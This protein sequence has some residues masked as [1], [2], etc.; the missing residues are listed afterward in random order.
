MSAM[1]L[2]GSDAVLSLPLLSNAHVKKALIPS[3]VAKPVSFSRK[4]SQHRGGRR[5]GSAKQT[6]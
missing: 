6:L 1:V 4:E 3:R 5:R 2:R